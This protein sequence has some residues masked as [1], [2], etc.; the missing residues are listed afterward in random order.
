[1]V[2]IIYAYVLILSL[3]V[4]CNL[5][6]LG[7]HECMG[8]PQLLLSL[9]RMNSLHIHRFHV[10]ASDGHDNQ[11]RSVTLASYSKYYTISIQ[12]WVI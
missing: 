12:M 3:L 5:Y 10:Y 1:M 6:S 7:D 4:E 2:T 11:Q 9:L 8:H